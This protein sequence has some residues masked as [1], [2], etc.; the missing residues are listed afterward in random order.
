M[1]IL[2]RSQEIKKEADE[3][4]QKFGLLNIIGK[5]G[6][7]HFTGSYK[8]DLMLKKDIDISLVCDSL[9]VK[10]FTQLGKELIDILETPSAYYRN[11]RINPIEKRPED[12][13]YWGINIGEWWIDLWAMNSSVFQRS[14]NYIDN[15]ASKLNGQNRL[16]IL[17]L[18]K[19]FLSSGKYGKNFGSR[20]LYD[21]VLNYN[22]KTIDELNL[23]LKNNIFSVYEYK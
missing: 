17:E 6:D 5:Y 3:L 10:E 19:E 7:I 11:T 14:K 21:A 16:I 22:V 1:N 20:E 2:T 18:K 8:L 15:I 9:S 23:Y 13:L 12:A 4:L